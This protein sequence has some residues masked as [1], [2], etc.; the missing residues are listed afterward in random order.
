MSISEADFQIACTELNELWEGDGVFE[1]ITIIKT[2]SH[3]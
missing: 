3:G 2:V 1:N